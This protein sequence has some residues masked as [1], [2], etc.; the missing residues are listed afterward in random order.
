[1]PFLSLLIAVLSRRNPNILLLWV[2]HGEF[3]YQHRFASK[4]REKEK[5]SLRPRYDWGAVR[6]EEPLSAGHLLGLQIT[7]DHR[8]IDS[9]GSKHPSEIIWPDSTPCWNSYLPT[10][11]D[12]RLPT[13]QSGAVLIL[14]KFHH[15][16]KWHLPPLN[17]HPSVLNVVSRKRE[18]DR[19][20]AT[21][22]TALWK[23]GTGTEFYPWIFFFSPPSNPLP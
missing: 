13:F 20:F 8:I 7:K 4:P 15:L 21:W 5:L 11:W 19:Y 17:S 6:G 2:V 22:Q 14:K 23:Y 16:L 1:M 18:H 9:Q 3:F 10:P 12:R